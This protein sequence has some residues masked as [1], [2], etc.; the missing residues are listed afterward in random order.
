V[1]SV[2]LI[3]YLR[4]ATCAALGGGSGDEITNHENAR[5]FAVLSQ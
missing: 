4:A 1:L 5:S 3:L 2:F